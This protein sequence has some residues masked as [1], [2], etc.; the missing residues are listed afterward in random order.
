MTDLIT[1][2]TDK[3]KA[4]PVERSKLVTLLV[5][6]MTD[7]IGVAQ[8]C[9]DA[10]KAFTHKYFRKNPVGIMPTPQ[11]LGLHMADGTIVTIMPPGVP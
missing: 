3:Y 10:F 6:D 1:Y 4:D 5:D 2:L 9:S 8:V 11:G 7:D